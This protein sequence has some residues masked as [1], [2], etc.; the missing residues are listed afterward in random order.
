[1]TAI[2]P[3][4]DGEQPEVVERVTLDDFHHDMNEH[5]CARYRV[6]GPYVMECDKW[7][8]I[9]NR[10]ERAGMSVWVALDPEEFPPRNER[11]RYEWVKVGKLWIPWTWG[12]ALV[13][14]LHSEDDLREFVEFF[15]ETDEFWTGKPDRLPAP[16]GEEARP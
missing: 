11:N 5:A 4:D 13:E 6:G 16:E 3:D 8:T 7:G 2:Q 12:C 15:P 1:M 10:G 9:D 14:C